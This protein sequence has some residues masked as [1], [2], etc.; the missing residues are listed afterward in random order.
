MSV[1]P[2]SKAIRLIVLVCLLLHHV[3]KIAFYLKNKQ[4]T[5]FPFLKCRIIFMGRVSQARP[6]RKHFEKHIGVCTREM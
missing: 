4:D 1:F 2:E 3:G 6:T 5:L